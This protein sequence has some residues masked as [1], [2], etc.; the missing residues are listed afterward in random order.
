MSTYQL[1]SG[2]H[3]RPQDGRCAMEWVAY[4]AGEPHSDQ[5]VCVSPLL[6]SFCI[7]VNDGLPDGQRQRLRPYLARTIGTAGDGLDVDRAWLCTDWLVREYA[8][9]FL[10]LVPSL[11]ADADRLRSL[12]PVL[13]MEAVEVAMCDLTGARQRAVA[14]RVAAGVAARNAAWSA[15]WVAAG[16]AAGVAARNAA[17]VAARNAARNAAWVAARVAAGV[18]ARNAA[19]VAARNAARDALAPT[20]TAL[21]NSVLSPGGLLDRMLPTEVVQIPVVTDWREVCGVPA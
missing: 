11:A 13:T 12:S 16:N 19:G 4:L 14:A 8:P 6:R 7:G 3:A 1:S 5:P 18:A 2:S 21:Q 17:G 9:A 10:S 15:A 20:V